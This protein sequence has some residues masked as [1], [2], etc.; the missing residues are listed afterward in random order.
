VEVSDQRAKHKGPTGS[1]AGA[2]L[3]EAE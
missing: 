3:I 2:I 1:S